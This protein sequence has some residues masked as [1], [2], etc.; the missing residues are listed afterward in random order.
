M[1]EKPLQRATFFWFATTLV[2]ILI[3]IFSG[4]I[5]M[6][7]SAYSSLKGEF[8]AYKSQMYQEVKEMRGEVREI[9]NAVIRIE[10]IFERVELVE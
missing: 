10:S 1:P 2:T 3:A 5:A 9:N 4:V 7:T 8:D 6:G